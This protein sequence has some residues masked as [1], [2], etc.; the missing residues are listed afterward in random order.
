[1]QFLHVNTMNC[2]G[3]GSVSLFATASLLNH[4]CE[5]NLHIS[6][7]PEERDRG[8]EV[9][10]T[11]SEEEKR[12]RMGAFIDL[13]AF[14]QEKSTA[15]SAS[16]LLSLPPSSSP[17]VSFEASRRIEEGEELTISYTGTHVTKSLL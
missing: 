14:I 3:E 13:P 11:W 16:T 5:S 4:S 12:E 6:L 2:G 8:E 1:M 10:S 15:I 9:T 17:L 7:F